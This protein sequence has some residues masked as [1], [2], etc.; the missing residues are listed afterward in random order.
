MASNPLQ[1]TIEISGVLSPSLQA[2]IKNAVSKLEEMSKETLDSAGAAEKL[3]AEIGAQE[4]V[5]KSLQKGYADYIVSGKESSDEAQTLADK[6]QELSGELEE[7]RGTLQAAEK[8]A[9]RLADTQDDSADAYTKLERK[10]NAQQDEL[11][12]LRREYANV[13]LEQGKTSKEAKQ[14]EGKISSLS[15]ELDKNEKKLRDVGEA[16]E[17][18]GRKAENSSEGYTVLKNVIAN[19]ATEAISKAVESF[20]ELAT[21]GDTLLPFGNR[22]RT[23]FSSS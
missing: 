8:A 14:L 10:I 19:L 6:I 22:R 15:G 16:A 18:A 13:V 1:S 2:A 3:S 11:E 17:D 21:E 20:K 7:N 12:A 4:S 9:K 5:L 23:C